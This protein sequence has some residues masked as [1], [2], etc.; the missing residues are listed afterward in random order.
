MKSNL[1][2]LLKKKTLFTKEFLIKKKK[3]FNL[4]FLKI[5][6]NPILIKEKE[7]I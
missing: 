2:K 7:F 1:Y 3:K 6:Y 4:L 5:A